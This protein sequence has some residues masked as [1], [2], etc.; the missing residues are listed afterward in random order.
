MKEQIDIRKV[1]GEVIDTFHTKDHPHFSRKSFVFI[2]KL[3]DGT[4]RVKVTGWTIKEYEI[5]K[6]GLIQLGYQVNIKIAR[7]I[8]DNEPTRL[9]VSKI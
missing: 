2:D 7:V 9:I 4:R 1:T 6:K 5:A 8:G 3:P